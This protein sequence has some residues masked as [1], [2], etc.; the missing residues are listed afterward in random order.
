M[1]KRQRKTLTNEERLKLSRDIKTL[2]MEVALMEFFDVRKNII[3]PNVS[4]GLRLHECDLLKVSKAG[5]ATEVEIKVSRADL[6][7][8]FEKKHTHKN[9]KIKNFFYAVPK[10]LEAYALELI[11]EHAGLY[12]VNTNR[13]GTK[14]VVEEVRASEANKDARKL[15]DNEINKLLKLGCMRI[16]SLKKKLLK[17]A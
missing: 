9:K 12:V 15:T 1:I 11:P 7:K 8:D 13:N 5:Y 3:V 16:V 6:R 17:T 4:Y 14:I 10:H 2:D